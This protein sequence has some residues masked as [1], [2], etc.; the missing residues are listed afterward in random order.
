MFLRGLFC[1]FAV[2]FIAG[3]GGG[4]GGSNNG[5]STTVP[6]GGPSSEIALVDGYFKSS[7]SEGVVFQEHSGIGSR[8]MD[9]G[10]PLVDG[11][12]ESANFLVFTSGAGN[13][14]IHLVASIAEEALASVSSQLNLTIDE[15][16]DYR[17]PY[18]DYVLDTLYQVYGRMDT[19]IG[20]VGMHGAGSLPVAESVFTNTWTDRERREFYYAYWHGLDASEQAQELEDAGVYRGS[21]IDDIESYEVPRKIQVCLA[22]F[23]G[24]GAANTEGLDVRPPSNLQDYNQVNNYQGFRRIMWHEMVHMT[25]MIITGH[26]FGTAATD[27]WYAEG[28]AEY[29]SHGPIA[30]NSSR[31]NAVTNAKD[32]TGIQSLGLDLGV[33]YEVLHASTEYLFGSGGGRLSSGDGAI[34]DLWLTIRESGLRTGIYSDNNESTFTPGVSLPQTSRAVFQEAFGRVFVRNG[35]PF[36]YGEYE[37]EY[38]TIHQNLN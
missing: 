28:V 34:L 24:V 35:I 36:T 16:L 19:Q 11:Y 30:S 26:F 21:P 38:V 32:S 20:Y 3:C 23:D 13:D 1:F 8:C 5:G 9:E 33:V 37:A 4:G 12:F 18:S 15:V 6:G 27:A 7:S 29:L 2:S 25:S 10:I 14:D 17:R 22:D 31:F